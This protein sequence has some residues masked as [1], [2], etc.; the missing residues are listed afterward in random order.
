MTAVAMSKRPREIAITMIQEEI[1]IAQCHNGQV[2]LICSV[3]GVL[4]S[5]RVNSTS[6]L[7]VL[8]TSAHMFV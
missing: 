8:Q 3:Q 7:D 5:P 2:A 6:D 4:L 1:D